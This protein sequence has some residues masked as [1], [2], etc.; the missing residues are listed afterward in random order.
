MLLKEAVEWE[1]KSKREIVED[2][3]RGRTLGEEQRRAREKEQE[4][5]GVGVR[6][7]E[8]GERI[9]SKYFFI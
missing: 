7:G 6:V 3:R 1:S 4:R 2:E 8:E 9:G 5:R